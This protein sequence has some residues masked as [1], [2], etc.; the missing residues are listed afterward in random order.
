MIAAPFLVGSGIILRLGETL[1][2]RQTSLTTSSTVIPG[3]TE[4]RYASFICAMFEMITAR[5]TGDVAK[6]TFFETPA[7]LLVHHDPG[8]CSRK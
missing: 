6:F 2:P 4:S 5:Y 7:F 1:M 8:S 3:W